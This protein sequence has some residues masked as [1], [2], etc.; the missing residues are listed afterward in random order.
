L[1]KTN[2]SIAGLLLLVLIVSVHVASATNVLSGKDAKTGYWVPREP[3][4]A[5]YEI[6][7]SIDPQQG[8][9]EGK[10]NIR[11]KNTTNRSINCLAIKWQP[12]KEQNLEITIEDKPI[13]FVRESGSEITIIELLEAIAPNEGINIEVKFSASQPGGM[14][15][16]V[17]P[18]T[19]WYPRIWWGFETRD[20][21]DVK[22][23]APKTYKIATSGILNK[24]TGYYQAKSIRSF[25][26]ILLKDADVFEAKAQDV[27]VKCY[28][29]SNEKKCAELLLDTA[30]DAI[31]F[32][33]ER[34]GFYPNSSLT[35]IPGADRPMGGYP[36]AT[37]IVSIHGMARMD[38]M[39]KLH[40]Q[41]IAAHEVGHQYWLEYVLS[42]DP[43]DD[44][45]WLMIGLGIY[46]DREYVRAKG[47]GM[48][49]HRGLMERYI[50]GVREGN[51]TTVNV[52]EEE[53]TKIKF[54]FNNVVIHGKGY[55][56]ISALDCLLG[57]D[58]FDRAYRRCLKEYGGRRLGVQD[59]QAVCEA[60]SGQDL[61]W[62]FEQWLNSNK[63]LSYEITSKKCERNGDVFVSEIEVKRQGDL[64]MP[65]PVKATFEDGSKQVKFTNRLLDTNTVRFESQ[66][67]LKEARLDPDNALALIVPPPQLT[68][69]QLS[70]QIR[71]LSWTD[72]GKQAHEIF[73][74]TKDVKLPRI[75]DWFKLG[76]VLYDGQYYNESLK[77]WQMVENLSGKGTM[78]YYIAKVWKGHN[79]DLLGQRDKAI[80]CYEVALKCEQEGDWQR[81]DQYRMVINQNW[82]KQRLET[83]FERDTS[84]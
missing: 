43:V 38:E 68:E 76:L 13:S 65:V 80:E 4:K 52:S 5:Q 72:S 54:D 1:W 34:F 79:Y 56:I 55:C 83:P 17:L 40:W 10:E 53:A 66:T 18:L 59:F 27:I 36:V 29:R 35:I 2:L 7:F 25:G 14:D 46:A 69:Q 22:V 32:Y 63:D 23:N 39:P 47:L 70:Q 26:I 45:G 81:H 16:D 50:S 33:W 67:A 11:F 21:F 6:E 30:V 19:Y 51:D 64:C 73:E 31:N 20:D 9:S 60:E 42:K 44:I 74:K 24:T 48:D 28:Y 49:K 84:K 62:F 15:R 75:D 37:N 78:D 58:V 8:H 41:W 61:E 82:V 3:P 12:I 77:A 57:Q 71:Q